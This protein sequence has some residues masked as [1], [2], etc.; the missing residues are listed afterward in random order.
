M[1][2]QIENL[3]KVAITV[4]NN[5]WNINKD[6]DRLVIV[7]V[8]DKF[9]TYLSRKPVPAGTQITNREYWIPFSSL[10]EELLL[11]YNKFIDKYKDQLDYYKES[12]DKFNITT[13]KISNEFNN[14]KN[15]IEGKSENCIYDEYSYIIDQRGYISDPDSMIV[16]IS[17]DAKDLPGYLGNPTTNFMSWLK[18]NTHA[19]Y[20]T[21][22]NKNGLILRQ[23]NDSN[24]LLF[25]N[26]KSS[27]DYITGEAVND[28]DVFIKFPVDIYYKFEKVDNNSDLVLVTFSRKIPKE[29]DIN[30]WKKWNQYKLIAVY[31]SVLRGGTL[32]SMSNNKPCGNKHKDAYIEY[33]KKRGNR[34]DITDYDTARFMMFLFYGYYHSLN[35]KKICGY[36]TKTEATTGNSYF[37]KNGI[38]D[39][40]GMKDTTIE[41]GTFESP[42]NTDIQNGYGN[43]IKTI[44]FWGLESYWGD[45][46]ESIGNV[47][48][49]EIGNKES[50]GSDYIINYLSNHENVII[51][52]AYGKD[53]ICNKDNIYNNFYSADLVLAI[54]ENNIITRAIEIDSLSGNIAKLLL[55]KHGDIIPKKIV[56]NNAF[57]TYFCNNG[58]LRVD[59]NDDI[60]R[61]GFSNNASN[62]ISCISYIA[63][64]RNTPNLT[65]RIIFN[66]DENTV[67]IINL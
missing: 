4:D 14:I 2:L 41:S 11:D 66:G 9:S 19:Y 20:A 64:K 24:R 50:T 65:S 53:Y 60:I 52:D 45:M 1:K 46:N 16:P 3:G 62:G 54:F 67:H 29:D 38:N 30:N 26:G 40:L 55:G 44:N 37:K 27:K 56:T 18:A 5:Y 10:K 15:V 32:H 58:D 39:K 49:M 6:Y 17:T 61:S 57:D 34:F 7:E 28:V 63:S 22:D 42:I 48:I 51:T 33:V 8:K 21:S 43:T 23:L 47:K 36:G 25:A 13:D 59:R 12:I 35:S 31:P